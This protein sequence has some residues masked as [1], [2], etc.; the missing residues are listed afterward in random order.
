MYPTHHPKSFKEHTHKS[1]EP[2]TPERSKEKKSL[3]FYLI[4]TASVMGI[5]IVGGLVSGSLA[6]LSDAGHMFT[7]LFT[8]SLSLFALFIASKPVDHQKTYGYFRAEILTA[9]F[10]GFLLI[11][12]SIFIFYEAYQ[13]F[14]HGAHVR[15]IPMLWVGSLGLI[16]NLVGVFLLH[17]LRK[18]NL[19]LR[20][21]FLHV[22][23]DTLSSLAVVVGAL[24]IYFTQWEKI[25]SLLSFMIAIL[26]LLWAVKLVLESIHILME[27]TPKHIDIGELTQFM[28]QENPGIKEIHDVHVWAITTNMYAMTAHVTVEE[29][30]V[31]DCMKTTEAM[32]RLLSEKYHIEHVNLQYEC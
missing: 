7:D 24:V 13:R 27:S 8:L 19:N 16:I 9:L 4:L 6:L 23:S 22:L 32:N 11:V 18:Q 10:N 15:E 17:D 26:I 25:D 5:E 28:K 14:Q 21:A 31:S 20:S 29:C 2:C 1:S 30:S 12:V 3:L